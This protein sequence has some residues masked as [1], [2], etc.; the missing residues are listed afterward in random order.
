MKA[1]RVGKWGSCSLLAGAILLGGWATNESLA[2]GDK[3]GKPDG[4]K[5]LVPLTEKKDEKTVA[6]SMDG[7]PWTSVFQWLSDQTN[8]EVIGTLKPQGTFSFTGPTKK[9]YTIPQVIDVINAGLLANSQ[10]QKY[11][12]INGPR[13]FVIVPAEE[14]IDPVHLQRITPEQLK[15]HGET[16]IV[17]M[18]MPLRS[19][20]AEDMAPVLSKLKGPFGEIVALPVVNKLILIDTVANLKILKL[21]IDEIDDPKN[22]NAES[23]T[24][25]CK[26]I[27]PRDAERILKEQLGDPRVMAEQVANQAR[28]QMFADGNPGGGNPG[29]GIQFQF[30]NGGGFQQPGGNPG[31][32]G[33]GAPAA[34]AG[35]IRMHYIS[36]D[37][38]HN[39]VLVS[40]PADKLAQAKAILERIDKGDKDQLP[41]PRGGDPK[42]LQY[43]V[44]QGN[45]VDIAKML[46][47]QYRA[48][49]MVRISA[50]GN[51]TILVYAG[52]TDQL[53]IAAQIPKGDTGVKSARIDS[54]SVDQDKLV[55]MLT[56][57][58]GD[59]TKGSAP[60]IAAI[61]GQG[62][63]MVHGSTS[64]I[65]DIQAAVDAM[66]G[67]TTTEGGTR[68]LPNQRIITIKEG[69]AAAVADALSR[70]LGG[71]RDNPVEVIGGNGPLKPK[72]PPMPPAQPMK[73]VDPDQSSAPKQMDR[74]KPDEVRGNGAPGRLYVAAQGG[75][76]A[77]P[78]EKPKNTDK[79]ARP[80]APP[81]K[82]AAIGNKIIITSE[83]PQAL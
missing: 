3:G 64:Q 69:S 72:T 50:A 66:N 60:T 34:P 70:T 82:I 39:L 22:G 54:G 73:P 45:A 10:T 56:Q 11:V 83:D 8:K 32:G 67:I 68:I 41:N 9:M 20:V 12:L 74:A 46:Q 63:I 53:D 25:E 7:K 4:D 35:K 6:F 71:L 51:N 81:I 13:E 76:L 55:A 40:G 47:E 61:D 37:E 48:P 18:Q 27:K 21:T 24:H 78:Q 80:N 26:F 77:D 65:A 16:E 62:A 49:S 2:Q 79:P 52:P 43:T 19:A 17:S 57:L 38:P 44:P 15:D 14:K 1:G 29:G 33:R 58:Y 28:A 31:R 5:P 75:Q 59:P 36:I 23:F 42:L 30:P